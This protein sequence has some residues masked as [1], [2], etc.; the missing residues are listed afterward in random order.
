VTAAKAEHA[1]RI[2][3]EARSSGLRPIRPLSPSSIRRRRVEVW[4]VTVGLVCTVVAAVL[5]LPSLP[6][7]K[8]LDAT[9][10]AARIGLVVLAAG[11]T[12]YAVEKEM[13]LRRLSRLLANERALNTALTERLREHSLLA[14][15]GRAVSSVAEVGERLPVVLAS[16]VELTGARAASIWLVGRD[17]GLRCS[18]QVGGDGTIG[19]VVDGTQLVRRLA[20]TKHAEFVGNAWPGPAAEGADADAGS[21]CAPLLDGDQPVGILHLVPAPERPFGEYLLAPLDGFAR[22]VGPGIAGARSLQVHRARADELLEMY[23]LKSELLQTL[24]RRLHEPLSSILG[25]VITLRGLDLSD[26]DR[27]AIIDVVERDTRQALSMVE[28]LGEASSAREAGEPGSPSVVDAGAVVTRLAED[29]SRGGLHVSVG[30]VT[31]LPVRGDVD[32]LRRVLASLAQWLFDRGARSV[33][34][35][36]GAQE[37]DAVLTLSGSVARK[38]MA[39]SPRDRGGERPEEFPIVRAVIAALGGQVTGPVQDGTGTAFRIELP[40]VAPQPVR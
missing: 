36:G 30:R 19:T 9:K 32:A 7:T 39:G 2:T 15:V 23:R 22:T 6:F 40:L 10:A 5:A 25:S 12:A 1:E 31:E 28:R 14:D 29:L 4:V 35:A 33:A 26:A 37:G 17:G 8:G 38:R 21:L 27:D 34:L 24:S 3:R 20:T 13:H 11:F 18:A 16:A